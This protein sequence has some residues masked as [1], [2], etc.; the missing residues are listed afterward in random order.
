MALAN[1]RRGWE[2]NTLFMLIAGIVFLLIMTAII[3]KR[4]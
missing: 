2:M 1:G 3:V 4:F